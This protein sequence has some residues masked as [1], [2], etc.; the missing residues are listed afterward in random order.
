MAETDELNL[1]VVRKQLSEL[2]AKGAHDELLEVV[3]A[4]LENLG[5]RTASLEFELMRLR[6]SSKGRKSEKLD[7]RQL[8]LL[9]SLVGESDRPAPESAETREAF[10]DRLDGELDEFTDEQLEQAE[11][12]STA[13]VLRVHAQLGS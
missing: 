12:E 13:R 6:K 8:Q 4:L 3:L 9:L 10:D 1:D 7:P 11:G 2:L 5:R